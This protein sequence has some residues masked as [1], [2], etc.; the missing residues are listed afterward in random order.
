MLDQPALLVIWVPLRPVLVI[1]KNLFDLFQRG[2][3]SSC[4]ED[5]EEVPVGDSRL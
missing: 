4:A 3:D 1:A 5:A 2:L